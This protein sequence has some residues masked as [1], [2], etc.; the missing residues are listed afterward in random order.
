MAL[1]SLN[2][3]V[4]SKA[5]PDWQGKT[6]ARARYVVRPA[7]A[8]TVVHA[9]TGLDALAPANLRAFCQQREQLAGKNGRV[10]EC[11]IVALPIEATPQ[12]R[13]ELVQALAEHVTKGQAPY[14]AALHDKPRDAYNPHAHVLLFDETVHGRPRAR[15]RRPKII[16][17]S[18][19]NALENLRADWSTL[20]NRMMEDWGYRAASAIDHRSL[21]TQAI[22]RI[23]EL[24][25]GATVRAMSRK[26]KRPTSKSVTDRES[27]SVDWPALDGGNLRP[28]TNVMIRDINAHLEPGRR[29]LFQGLCL[30]HAANQAA[31]P[32]NCSLRTTR[33]KASS[34]ASNLDT[35]TGDTNRQQPSWLPTWALLFQRVESRGRYKPS[36]LSRLLNAL[37]LCEDGAIHEEI[38]RAHV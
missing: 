12:Q 18:R 4:I 16:G 33:K 2:H 20:H 6:Y 17:L 25:E 23:P 35:Q 9:R 19:K 37:K 38:G 7:A 13:I 27:R 21:R 36:R 3:K 34:A 8:R 1:Y 30:T 22:Q 29:A 11:L 15:G 10:A 24:H 26:G 32:S 31:I 5:A 28:E 14:L